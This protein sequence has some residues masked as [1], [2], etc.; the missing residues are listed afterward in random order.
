MTPN[1]YNGRNRKGNRQTERQR[2]RQQMLIMH[3]RHS[4][5]NFIE[6]ENIG[7]HM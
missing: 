6:Y 3:I 4:G 1:A 5:K 7:G 2:Q